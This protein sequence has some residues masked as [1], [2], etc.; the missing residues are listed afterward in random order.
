MVVRRSTYW[1]E[2]FNAFCTVCPWRSPEGLNA[3]T[4]TQAAEL[5][6]AA[7][8]NAKEKGLEPKP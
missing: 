4:A 3:E 5:H 7:F 6:Q 8:S 1:S 2:F